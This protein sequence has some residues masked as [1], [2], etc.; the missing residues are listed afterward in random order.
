MAADVSS[1]VN[2]GNSKILITR[3]LLGELSKVG[4]K[5]LDPDLQIPKAWEV[6][7]DLKVNLNFHFFPH[8]LLSKIF[9]ILAQIILF[10]YFL[11]YINKNTWL[12]VFFFLCIEYLNAITFVL[13]VYNSIFF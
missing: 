3:D 6:P 2:S 4:N 1:M 8:N 12:L 10:S 7:L 5:D 9:Y 13:F 11:Y